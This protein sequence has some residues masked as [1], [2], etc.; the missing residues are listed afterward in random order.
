MNNFTFLGPAGATFSHEAYDNLAREYGTPV[1]SD[2]NIYPASDNRKIIPSLLEY[3]GYAAIAIE[4]LVGGRVADPLESFMTLLGSYQQTSDVPFGIIG[5]IKKQI[6]FCLMVKPGVDQALVNSIVSHPRG[7]Q[8]CQQRI[9]DWGIAVQE[10][11]SNGEAARLVAEHPDYTRAAALAPRSAAELYGLEI[12]SPAFEDERAVTTFFLLGPKT[13]QVVVEK[14]NR[15]L[16][17]FDLPHQPGALVKALNFFALASL[18]LIQVHSVHT[19]NGIYHFAI[20]IELPETEL[21]VFGKI[22]R[23]FPSVVKHFLCFG[24]F[25]IRSL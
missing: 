11:A 15:V 18:N 3:G 25:P 14:E 16:I 5:A 2:G 23:E 8:A 12:L 20:E 1:S 21:E 9:K 6:N 22:M 13:H 10:V 4:T 24:P 19:R 17:I 7:I